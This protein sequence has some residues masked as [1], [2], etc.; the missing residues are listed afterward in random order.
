VDAADFEAIGRQPMGVVMPEARTVLAILAV[1]ALP[2]FTSDAA[3][4]TAGHQDGP[5]SSNETLISTTNGTR[6]LGQQLLLIK[7]SLACISTTYAHS[8]SD[9]AHRLGLIGRHPSSIAVKSRISKYSKKQ[10]RPDYS[11]HQDKGSR[12]MFDVYLPSHLSDVL[13]LQYAIWLQLSPHMN[14]RHI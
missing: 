7:A 5:Y 4:P 12:P 1:V 8:E 11:I 6:A 9:S 3:T 2:I 10:V 14:Y 13:F